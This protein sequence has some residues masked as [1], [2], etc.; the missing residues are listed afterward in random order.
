M[1]K[2]TLWKNWKFSIIKYYIFKAK[3]SSFNVNQSIWVYND[4]IFRIILSEAFFYVRKILNKNLFVWYKNYSL[5]NYPNMFI[6]SESYKQ[7]LCLFCN[8]HRNFNWIQFEKTIKNLWR[9]DWM[10]DFSIFN[11]CLFEMN[12][13]FWIGS[14]KPHM[15]YKSHN[16]GIF[17]YYS[18]LYFVFHFHF[19][20]I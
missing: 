5:W 2:F 20:D 3:W 8:N 12:I 1:F 7:K 10:V 13:F 15:I 16:Y 18:V 9:Y 6:T 11:F 19:I 4:F 14:Y 17:V